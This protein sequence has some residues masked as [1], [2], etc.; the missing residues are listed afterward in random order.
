MSILICFFQF[1]FPSGI[2]SPYYRILTFI[3][4][5]L[6]MDL[7]NSSFSERVI[8]IIKHIPPGRVLTYGRI[9]LLAGNPR[10]AR[11][12]SWLL[13]SSTKKHDL[14]W[15]RVINAQG[16]SSCPH[17]ADEEQIFLLEKEGVAF[18]NGAAD[19]KSCLWEISSIEEI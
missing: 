8:H 3:S 9:A 17:P 7:S 6:S 16:R 1:S 5:E 2:P 13:H 11:G 18:T 15:H 4:P 12:V 19:L 14:P 10:G